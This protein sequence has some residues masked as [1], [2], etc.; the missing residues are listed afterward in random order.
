MG[1]KPELAERF[2]ADIDAS[3]RSNG[4]V[5]ASYARGPGLNAY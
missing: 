3:L 5:L 4:S 1:V 2:L